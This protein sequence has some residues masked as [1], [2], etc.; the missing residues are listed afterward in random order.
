VT[1]VLFLQSNTDDYLADSLLHGLRTLLGA[2]V[3]DAPRRDSMY[4]VADPSRV[5]GR[6]FTLYGTLPDVDVDRS[7]AIDRAL[8]GEFDVVVFADIARYWGPWAQLRARLYELKRAGVT[9]AALD[10]HDWE[11]MYPHGPFYWK[12]TRPWPLPRAEGRIAFFKRELT[13]HTARM[14]YYGLLPADAAM[15]RLRRHVRPIA[16]SIPEEKLA[17]GEEPKTKL[18]ATHVVDPEVQALVPGTHTSY[19]F[20]D[21]AAYVGDL[22]ASRFGITT[23]RHGW[24][25]MRHYEQAAAGCVPCFRDLDRKAPTCAPH[26]L[27]GSNCVPYK[28]PRALLR[29]LEAMGEEEYAGLRAGALAWARRNTTRVR[30][31]EFLAAIGR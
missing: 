18:L 14:R 28:D 26:G 5:Y 22:R 27:D 24:D 11:I 15:R 12:G 9:L 13:P 1:R 8:R 17:T 7:G 20:A 4:E 31:Q 6:G 2:D 30:A 19:A 21:E 10:G 3:V 29:R 25:C 23:K 16:F